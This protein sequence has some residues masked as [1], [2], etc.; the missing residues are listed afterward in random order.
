MEFK[1]T[2]EFEKFCD[3]SWICVCGRLMT[4]LHMSSCRKLHK[5][6]SKLMESGDAKERKG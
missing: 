1:T 5:I 6:R 4:G 3:E 2:E